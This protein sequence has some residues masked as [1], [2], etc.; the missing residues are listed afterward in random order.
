MK[1]P[2]ISA[3][4]ALRGDSHAYVTGYGPGWDE[5][6]PRRNPYRSRRDRASRPPTGVTESASNRRMF[7]ALMVGW[8]NCANSTAAHQVRRVSEVDQRPSTASC[9]PD[10]IDMQCVQIYSVHR[11]R[12]HSLPPPYR[13]E[14][15]LEPVPGWD[16]PVLRRCR[17]QFVERRSAGSASSTTIA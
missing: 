10:V 15:S 11:P 9:S 1:S 16:A 14:A 17:G 5:A 6:H 3:L 2:V 13:R 4:F 7:L 12:E 8:S